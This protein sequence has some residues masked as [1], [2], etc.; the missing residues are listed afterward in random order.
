MFDLY[1]G[2]QV[3]M[4]DKDKAYPDWGEVKPATTCRLSRRKTQSASGLIR[5][6]ECLP[7]SKSQR[8]FFEAE[9]FLQLLRLI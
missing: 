1:V 7:G 9:L 6:F 2:S 4:V 8:W 5:I 3:E